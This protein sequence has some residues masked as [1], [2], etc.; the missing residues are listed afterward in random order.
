MSGKSLGFATSVSAA[1]RG[2]G[3]LPVWNAGFKA[4]KSPTGWKPVPRL[5][6]TLS[7]LKE[8]VLWWR[9]R[10]APALRLCAQS[11][12]PLRMKFT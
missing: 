12:A 8:T 3:I 9:S 7:L 2:T 10:T 5:Q 6:L 11:D 1:V 4:C